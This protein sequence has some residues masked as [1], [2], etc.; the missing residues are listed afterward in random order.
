MNLA[1]LDAETVAVMAVFSIPILA[2]LASHQRS[3]AV[4][5]QTGPQNHTDLKEILDQNAH[6]IQEV[7]QLKDKVNA[8]TLALD[9]SPLEVQ[10]RISEGQ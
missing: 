10:A 8:L 7:R 6:L 9:R 3:M 2:I 4:I 1:F 5:K